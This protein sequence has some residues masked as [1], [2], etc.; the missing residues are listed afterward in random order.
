MYYLLCFYISHFELLASLPGLVKLPLRCK[1]VI[2]SRSA[3]V[4]DI[5]LHLSKKKG[6]GEM[7]LS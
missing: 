1:V 3:I 6:G 5:T 2:C 7:I 4:Q